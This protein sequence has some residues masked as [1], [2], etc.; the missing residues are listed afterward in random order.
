MCRGGRRAADRAGVTTSTVAHDP[1]PIELALAECCSGRVEYR[2]TGVKLRSRKFALLGVQQMLEPKRKHPATRRQRKPV[3]VQR[4]RTYPPPCSQLFAAAAVML[5]ANSS[6]AKPAKIAE[7]G[8]LCSVAALMKQREAGR[9]AQ[10]ASPAIT[11]EPVG[12]TDPNL[13]RQDD[14]QELD[15]HDKEH[16]Q[17]IAFTA[18]DGNKASTKERI[19]GFTR[20][21]GHHAAQRDPSC[22]RIVG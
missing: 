15:W 3:M 12:P 8:C 14:S 7:T 22:S 17:Q 4:R 2:P 5:T 11:R 20:I 21:T 16:N 18:I 1:K 10:I 6:V 13:W 19:S 9:V